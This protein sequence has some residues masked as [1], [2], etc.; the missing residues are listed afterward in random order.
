MHYVPP[1]GP[2]NATIMALGES[3]GREEVRQGRPFVGQ[4]GE[5]FEE[6]LES[7]GL[8][9]K[10]IYITNTVKIYPEFP[11]MKEKDDFFFHKT[12]P[13]KN[14]TITP[15]E[16]YMEGIL[17]LVHEI[18]QVQPHVIVP[19]GNYALWALC[20]VRGILARRGSILESTLI[21][22]QKVIPT[23]HP[24]Y[25]HHSKQWHQ[26]IL[27]EWDWQRI[28]EESISPRIV[29]PTA[30]FIVD[31]DS[32]EIEEA[33]ERLLHAEIMSVDTEWY[34][35]EQ[36][37]YIGFSDSPDWAITIPATSMQ[38]YRAYKK[39][40]SSDVPK[41]MQN[42]AFDAV[43]LHRRGMTVR[44]IVHDTMVAWNCCWG[45]I[46]KKSLDVQSS[47]LTRW[48]YYKDD[49]EF[50]GKNDTQGQVYCGKD[51]IVTLEGMNTMLES[52]FKPEVA[53]GAKGYEISMLNM[54]TF[55]EASKKGIR[56]DMNKLMALKAEYLKR[57]EET[58]LLVGWALKHP[59]N[60][61]SW[62]QVQKAVYDELGLGKD[63][64]DRSTSQEDLMDI[65]AS[66]TRMEI[67]KILTQIIRVRQDRNMVSRYIHEDIVDVDG[68][69]RTNWNIA[70]TRNGRY[71]TTDPWWNG[72]AQQTVPFDA[73]EVCI[74]DEGH[75]FV[76]WDLEQAEA[77]VVA[78]LTRDYEL[79]DAMDS[80]SDIHIKLAVDLDIFNMTYQEI[81][82]QCK[83][84][85]KDKTAPRVLSKVCRHAMNYDLTWSG[86]K[87]RV[88]KDYLDTN[89]GINAALAK[90][91][92]K[93]YMGLHSGLEAWW[94]QVFQEVKRRGHLT[95]DFGRRRNFLGK[96]FKHDHIHRDAIAFQPQSDIADL[97]SISIYEAQKKM[98]W[99]TCLHHGHDG[100]FFQVP[101][102]RE[103]ECKG[104]IAETMN[105]E[106]QL[107][108]DSIT[109]PAEIKSGHNWKEML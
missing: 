30:T 8:N 48:P 68:R 27:C 43:A 16:A 24:A 86:L 72:W 14:Q 108:R 84:V 66:E 78:V 34:G 4:A 6:L 77:R 47:V 56:A 13:K 5:T 70:G 40:L 73:R 7:V 51:C 80:G 55:I 21:P 25:F 63:R 58:E 3:P 36:L 53:G 33:V 71:S 79:L 103:E 31:P 54:D 82:D 28:M 85:G 64:K 22:G 100:G 65:A 52:E 104:I 20:Q 61:Q 109:I 18:R 11:G 76:G 41:I 67:K 57:A 60:C 45:D 1:E 93:R 39:L 29:L 9:R 99:A 46:R 98:P 105:R 38:A 94:E 101:L 83:K 49:L 89:V 23:I 62:P 88:N 90:L 17:G 37:A 12:G 19:M 91:L 81:V 96:M 92:H 106:I 69:I 32:A 2:T 42:A 26:F 35:P 107:G 59:I 87:A 97:T 44:R 50:V 102:D 75:I 10:E 95:N 15:T 74:A